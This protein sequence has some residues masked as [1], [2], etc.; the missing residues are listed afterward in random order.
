[1]ALIALINALST[2]GHITTPHAMQHVILSSHPDKNKSVDNFHWH[3][4]ALAEGEIKIATS[5]YN[6]DVMSAL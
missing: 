1:M 2:S 5:R 4:I 6:T 3:V